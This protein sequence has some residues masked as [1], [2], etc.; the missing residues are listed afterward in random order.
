VHLDIIKVLLPTD[1]NGQVPNSATDIHQ[2]GLDNK[3][4][5]TTRLTTPNVI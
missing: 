3:W 2:Q 4:S 5:H 1:A